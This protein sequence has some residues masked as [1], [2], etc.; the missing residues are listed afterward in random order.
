MDKKQIAV[1][2]GNNLRAERNR[3]NLS[4]E[5]LAEL[6]DLQ[7]SHISKIE[8][9]QMDIQLTTLISLLKALDIPFN[10]LYDLNE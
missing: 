1:I 5:R 6:A 9:G 10:K 4:Q 3:K 8:N 2:F 7:T